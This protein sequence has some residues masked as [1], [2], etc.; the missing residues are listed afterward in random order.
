MRCTHCRR[1]CW[2]SAVTRAHRGFSSDRR[3]REHDVLFLRQQGPKYPKWHLTAPLQAGNNIKL[4]YGALVPATELIGKNLL[5]VVQDSKG[6]RVVLQEPTLSSYIVNNERHATPIYPHDAN[7]IVA[8]LDLNLSRPGEEEGEENALPFEIFEAG[9]GMGSLTLHIARAIHAANPPFPPALRRAICEAKFRPKT[10]PSLTRVDLEQE[11]ERALDEYRACRRAILHTLDQKPKHTHAAYK[12]VR[13]FRRAQY[14]PSIDFHVGSVD[15][16][17]SKRLAESDGQPFLHR[18]ILDLPSAH[19]NAERVVESLLPNGIL[20]LFKPSI[21]QIADFQKWSTE[22][23]QPVRLEKVLEL[24]VSTT[25]DGVHDAGGGRHWDVKLVVPKAS[26][27]G[28]GKPVQ[29]MRPKVGDRIAGGGFVAVLRRWPA[30]AQSIEQEQEQEQE[31]ENNG[32]RNNNQ[33]EN[34]DRC[35]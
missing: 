4:S 7:T 12:L 5:D 11:A 32:E 31:D 21:S 2:R 17:L 3:I 6:N 33:E 14:L 29:V 1:L 23:R 34:H 16:Y 10:N 30:D 8:L 22:T 26:L 20:I 35:I 15:E 13:N 24:P 27:G 18:A 19:E 28:D 9:T 25:S